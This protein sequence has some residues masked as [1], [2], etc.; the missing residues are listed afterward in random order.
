MDQRNNLPSAPCATVEAAPPQHC[1]AFALIDRWCEIS[2]MS[3]RV[4]Y[5]E[6]GRGNLKAVKRGA[7]TLIDVQHGLAWLRSLPP[8]VIRADRRRERVA[9]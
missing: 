9:A 6:L 7:S 3:R 8:A 4:T 5:E 2:S 1:P